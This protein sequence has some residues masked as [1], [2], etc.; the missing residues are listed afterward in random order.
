MYVNHKYNKH[1]V[2]KSSNVTRVFSILIKIS[3]NYSHKFMYNITKQAINEDEDTI[4]M[5]ENVFNW[6]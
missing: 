2:Q 5:I 6:I 3:K 4:E 1:L